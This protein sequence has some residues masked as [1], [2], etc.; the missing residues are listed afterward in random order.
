MDARLER[1]KTSFMNSWFPTEGKIFLNADSTVSA[2][3]IDILFEDFL[4]RYKTAFP[5]VQGRVYED[6]ADN[7]QL[8]LQDIDNNILHILGLTNN[9][10]PFGGLGAVTGRNYTNIDPTVTSLYISEQ[11]AIELYTHITVDEWSG[12]MEKPVIMYDNTT[13]SHYEYI[14][15]NMNDF[16]ILYLKERVVNIAD[17]PS[18]LYPSV[19]AFLTYNLALTTLHALGRYPV[20]LALV[21]TDNP[22]TTLDPN[23]LSSVTI[24]G[25]LTLS[26]SN[27]AAKAYERLSELFN[28]GS[29]KTYMAEIEALYLDQLKIFNTLK[30][31]RLNGISFS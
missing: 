15:P 21:D 3:L 22:S 16:V 24:S 19:E 17:I 12:R 29:G 26:L 7:T 31:I 27:S 25:K 14:M 2:D 1:L 18:S 6:F 20:S 9:M 4:A 11:A 30:Y 28:N 13:D 10:T 23:S 5:A 8:P